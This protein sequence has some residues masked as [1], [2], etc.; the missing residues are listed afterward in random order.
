MNYIRLNSVL[1]LITFFS[2][3]LQ[4]CEPPAESPNSR[5]IKS[6]CENLLDE[7]QNELKNRDEIIK[8]HEE[9][10]SL[11][12]SQTDELKTQLQTGKKGRKN[13]K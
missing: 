2:L 12:Q 3:F 4:S 5:H 13:A 6:T 11:L 9:K 10:I 1:F 7:L 8:L